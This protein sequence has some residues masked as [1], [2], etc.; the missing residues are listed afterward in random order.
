MQKVRIGR[1][2]DCGTRKSSTTEANRVPV[3]LVTVQGSITDSPP[4]GKWR[5]QL[6]I[7]HQA[8]KPGS[9]RHVVAPRKNVHRDAMFDAHLRHFTR[10]TGFRVDPAP[11]VTVER[12]D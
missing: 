11:A 7:L 10:S 2:A 1:P 4:C 6:K 8:A 3:I 5:S 9:N 12:F